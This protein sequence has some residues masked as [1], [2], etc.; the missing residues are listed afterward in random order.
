[1]QFKLIK[2]GEAKDFILT[3]ILLLLAI[4]I[5]VSRNQ[6]GINSLRQVSITVVSL[7]QTPLS[8]VRIYRQAL[9]TNTYLQRQNILLQDELS[10]LRSIEQ[11]NINLRRMFEFKEQSPLDLKP[12]TIIGKELS[13]INNSL[14]ITPGA[15]EGLKPGMP[16]ITSDGLLGKI[17]L[18]NDKYAQVMPYYN[19]LFRVSARVQENQAPGIVSWSGTNMSELVMD[20]VPLTIRVDS[21]FVVET[22]GFSNQYP[23]GIPIGTVIRTEPEEGKETQRIYLKPSASLYNVSEGFIV[24]FSRDTSLINLETDYKEIFK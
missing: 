16:L 23:Q 4:S 2:V 17:V 19:S 15:S 21:G 5:A 24:K 14:T 3:A 20:F 10:R 1:M 13:G 12:V 18:I 22:S 9:N 11:E 7:L 6:G 8:S